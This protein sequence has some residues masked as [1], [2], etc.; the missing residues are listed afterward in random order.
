MRTLIVD[1]ETPAR[2]RLKRMLAS[3][4]GVEIVGEAQDGLQA[5]EMIAALSPDLALLDIQMPGLDGFGVV[6]A[7][8]DPPAVIF[9]T[10]YD[11]YAI[12]AFEVN[13]L[14]YLLKPFSQERLEKAIRRAQEAAAEGQAPGLQLAPLLESLAAG[15]RYLTRLAVRHQERIRLLDVDEIDWIGIQDEQTTVHTG[16]QVYSVHRSLADMQARL[17]PAHFFRAH[18]SAIV[19]LKQVQEIV[20]WFKGGYILRLGSGAEVELSRGQARALRKILGW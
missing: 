3:L 16:E 2:E 13:A 6:D 7:L 10:A 14:D 1:D 17:D 15:G 20:P 8:Q 18:R 5:L 12:R 4:A 19:N 9:V 11:E